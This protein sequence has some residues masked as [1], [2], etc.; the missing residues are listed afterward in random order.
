[1]PKGVIFREVRVSDRDELMAM[2]HEFFPVRYSTNFYD[3]MVQGIGMFG[4]QLCTVIAEEEQTGAIVGF[5]I[6]QILKYP[7][8][9]EDYDL[10]A[11]PQ[12]SHVMYILTLGV[13]ASHR[14]QGL[15][16]EILHRCRGLAEGHRGCGAVYLH[17]IHYNS[18]AMQLYSRM[19][20]EQLRCL[21]DFYHFEGQHHRAFL[22]ISF[23]SGY[24]KRDNSNQ[25]MT[26]FGLLMAVREWGWASM[27]IV[28]EAVHR[29]I[30]SLASF[31]SWTNTSN[32]AN[33]E[34][35]HHQ[36][37]RSSSKVAVSVLV[38]SGESRSDG[39]YSHPPNPSSLESA[40]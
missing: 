12:P 13:A 24:S 23:L 16:V 3:D 33:T 11:N 9:V 39:G 40:V 15:A 28:L 36:R 38:S 29:Y 5:A 30:P 22:F 1:M 18:A 6:T 37:Q 20:F 10:F 27:M 31:P 21:E 26:P 7:S 8:Q 34:S 32:S 4:G 17:V 25:I 2:H 35:N 14:R 19:S